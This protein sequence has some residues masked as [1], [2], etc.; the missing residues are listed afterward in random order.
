LKL[1]T[2]Q[3]ALPKP[4]A[5]RALIVEDQANFREAVRDLLE[6]DGIEVVGEASAAREA[7]Q[8]AERL[9]PDMTLI[10]VG[11]GDESGFDLARRFA[12]A[13]D[14]VATNVILISA[15]AP[16]DVAERVSRSPVLGFISK[17]ELSA[18]AVRGLL[19]DRIHGPGLRHEAL[20]YSGPE[21]FVAAA[22]PFV[23]HGLAAD[24]S[25]LAFVG[26]QQLAH[27]G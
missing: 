10:D 7:L 1:V 23:R 17:S 18:D 15:H 25:V 21:E 13:S 14:R 20:I 19:E 24:D 3:S 12:L 22:A 16:A 4:L 11:L 8:A 5:V 9:Q 6:R 26:E 27:D 2:L